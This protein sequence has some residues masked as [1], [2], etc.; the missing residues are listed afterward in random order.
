MPEFGAVAFKSATE[1][2]EALLTNKMKSQMQTNGQ[3]RN[4]PD[5]E[6]LVFG[7]VLANGSFAPVINEKGEELAFKFNDTTYTVPGTS[8]NFDMNLKYNEELDNVY[9]MGGAIKVDLEPVAVKKTSIMT[10]ES[11]VNDWGTLYQTTND[12]KKN[13]RALKA[14]N[15]NYKVPNEAKN[16]IEKIVPTSKTDP[17]AVVSV[18]IYFGSSFIA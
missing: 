15:K 5:G 18:T 3:W 8:Q 12:P 17:P 13:E 4:T 16:S 1:R 2:D 7:I 6:G 9:A 10:N 11:I 14:I